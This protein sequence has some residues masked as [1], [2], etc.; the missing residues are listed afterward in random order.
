MPLHR[1]L[2]RT[3]TRIS[4]RLRRSTETRSSA[5]RACRALRHA[6]RLRGSSTLTTAMPPLQV[7]GEQPA[8]RVAVRLHRA[9][10]VEVILRQVRERGDRE[11]DARRARSIASAADDTSI[12]TCVQPASRIAANVSCSTCGVG[13]VYGASSAVPAQRYVDRADHAG[14]AARGGEDALDEVR[15]RRLAVRAGDADRASSPSPDRRATRADEHAERLRASTARRPAATV[16]PSSSRSTT[17]AAAPARS[18]SATNAWPSLRSPLTA[19][20]TSPALDLARIVVHRADLDVAIADEARAGEAVDELARASCRIERAASP[21]SCSDS[22]SALVRRNS[23]SVVGESQLHASRRRRGRAADPARSPGP[24]P[25]ISTV[26]VRA[27][28]PRRAR[29]PTP[30]PRKSGIVDR[31]ARRRRVVG[32]GV[33]G[34]LDHGGAAAVRRRLR[35][36]AGSG[37]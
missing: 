14:L 2:L 10:D 24:M 6:R 15:R 35:R 1:R 31:A 27:C 37:S 21:I 32:D 19:T 28:A 7:I 13:V 23:P 4:A 8:L 5:R 34:R 12:T 26:E 18:R 25:S 20:N 33:R 30:M 3:T 16:T 22:S 36:L 29:A 9:V 17:I 11:V